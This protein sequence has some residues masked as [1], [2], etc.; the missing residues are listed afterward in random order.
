MTMHKPAAERVDSPTPSDVVALH[1]EDPV[2]FLRAGERFAIARIRGIQELG[3]LDLYRALEVREFGSRSRIMEALEQRDGVLR[4]RGKR[5]HP[6][7]LG[8]RRR[9]ESNGDVATWLDEDDEP[10]QRSENPVGG[11]LLD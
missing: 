10:Y 11:S 6:W 2:R 5:L 7:P 8:P 3:L 4:E 9:R 1:D